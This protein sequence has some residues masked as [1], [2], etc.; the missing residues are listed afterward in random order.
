MKTL[1]KCC[2]RH[3]SLMTDDFQV[4]SFLSYPSV[5]Y[6]RAPFVVTP[7]FTSREGRFS[8]TA[9]TTSARRRPNFLLARGRTPNNRISTRSRR[10]TVYVYSITNK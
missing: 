5:S 3:S 9:Q 4:L 10:C 2:R 6:K 8:T 7:Y 1:K